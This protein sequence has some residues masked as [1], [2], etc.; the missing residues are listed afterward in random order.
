[1]TDVRWQFLPYAVIKQPSGKYVIV[2]RRYKPIGTIDNSVW[3]DYERYAV[4]LK[5]TTA[6][7]KKIAYSENEKEGVF[8]LYGGSAAPVDK[9]RKDE[10]FKR[11]SV[12]MDVIV[13]LPER[14][15]PAGRIIP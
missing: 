11:L 7:R 12:L 4:H 10:Y 5:L 6:K 15:Y 1:M 3:Y 2:N 14:H 13:K 8:W 9:Q